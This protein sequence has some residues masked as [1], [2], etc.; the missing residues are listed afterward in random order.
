MIM[1][2]S[3]RLL[4]A[5]KKLVLQELA[6]TIRKQEATV[7]VSEVQDDALFDQFLKIPQSPVSMQISRDPVAQP[8]VFQLSTHVLKKRAFSDM[9]DEPIPEVIPKKTR[10]TIPALAL[11]STFPEI[12]DGSGLTK[13][14]ALLTQEKLRAGMHDPRGLLNLEGASTNALD[15]TKKLELLKSAGYDFELKENHFLIN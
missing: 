7:V 4:K 1:I 10:S 12:R 3:P 15:R 5:Y 9:V 14:R 2:V 8:V 13:K 6:S 11:L